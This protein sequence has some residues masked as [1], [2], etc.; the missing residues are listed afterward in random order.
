VHAGFADQLT[1]TRARKY[2]DLPDEALVVL[3]LDP[4]TL[5]VPVVVED[6]GA[7]PFPHLYGPLPVD[8]V[9]T[10]HT[11]PLTGG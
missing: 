9:L 3:E 11:W 2:A 10:E 1:G 5:S 8:E 7:G 4:A 6:L